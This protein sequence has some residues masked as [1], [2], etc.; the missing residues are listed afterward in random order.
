MVNPATEDAVIR[1]V[2]KI[3]CDARSVLFVTGAGVSADSGLPTYRG[4]GGL[5]DGEITED[6]VRIEDALSGPMFARRPALTWKYLWQIAAS[7]AGAVPNAAHD[8]IAA[9]E[10]EKDNVWVITQNVDGLHRFAGSNNLVEVHGNMYDLF[11]T[12]CGHDYAAS[13]LLS[14]FRD[15]PA[16]PLKISSIWILHPTGCCRP[17]HR[18]KP[19]FSSVPHAPP[20][21]RLAAICH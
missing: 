9:I 17:F 10:L 4:V 13:D 7:C 1:E 14:D 8:I 2:A 12:A 6:G 21:S 16:L 11:C 20:P 19:C 18:S 3:L 15:L 5:Y